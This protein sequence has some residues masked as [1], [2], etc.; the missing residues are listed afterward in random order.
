[1]ER[2]YAR[3]PSVIGDEDE[4]WTLRWIPG[5]NVKRR[6]HLIETVPAPQFKWGSNV[7]IKKHLPKRNFSNHVTS[8][9][10]HQNRL[11][12]VVVSNIF[13]DRMRLDD[14]TG[15]DL[16]RLVKIYIANG[17]GRQTSKP[18]WLDN[19]AHRCSSL[20]PPPF[21]NC[22]EYSWS[23]ILDIKKKYKRI[24]RVSSL[25]FN[26]LNQNGAVEGS[27]DAYLLKGLS[28]CR[29]LNAFPAES[30]TCSPRRSTPSYSRQRLSFVLGS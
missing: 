15:R 12:G 3:L 28:P 25:Q 5:Q 29:I 11:T 27:K 14:L 30:R 22:P 10:Q 9:T 4:G 21:V 26:G 8:S 1:M 13:Q 24:C 2:V 7:I 20:T 19:L 17:T 6:E 18:S 16:A 23:R